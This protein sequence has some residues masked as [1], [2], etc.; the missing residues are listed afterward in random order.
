MIGVVIG[1]VIGFV[2]GSESSI[3]VCGKRGF[4]VG[5]AGDRRF[6]EPAMLAIKLDFDLGRLSVSPLE[7][8]QRGVGR[9]VR[10]PMDR[11]DGVGVLLDLAAI[12]QLSERRFLVFGVAVELATND[13][14]NLSS[15]ASCFRCRQISPIRYV[16]FSCVVP[17]SESINCKVV[18][19]KAAETCGTACNRALALIAETLARCGSHNRQFVSRIR[20]AAS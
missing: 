7:N 14:G 3:V 10:S 17:R 9:V 11:G 4:V 20:S 6:F 2:I 1:V 15:F 13:N 8:L 12:S 16:S 5:V 19:H 18:N